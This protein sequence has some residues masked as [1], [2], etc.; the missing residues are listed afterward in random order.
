MFLRLQRWRWNRA[1]GRGVTIHHLPTLKYKRS[2]ANVI[3]CSV[4]LVLL[5]KKSRIENSKTKKLS[6]CVVSFPDCIQGDK[7]LLILFIAIV[8]FYIDLLLLKK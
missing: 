6:D 1:Q 4:T 7:Y 3:Y 8:L 5:E 2:P